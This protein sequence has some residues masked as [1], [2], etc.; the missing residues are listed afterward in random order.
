M[1]ELDLSVIGLENSPPQVGGVEPE[2]GGLDLSV[3]GL[4]NI[5]PTAAIPSEQS[6]FSKG[7][8]RGFNNV[9]A[10]TGDAIAVFGELL[11]SD[12]LVGY[13][14]SVS[15]KNRL[16]MASVG[17]PEVA[18]IEDVTNANDIAPWVANQLGQAI[19]S[20]FPGAT[21]AIAT[22]LGM[23]LVGFSPVGFVGKYS[24]PA[25]SAYLTTAFLGT[26]EASR[27]QKEL[28]GNEDY[29]DA[30]QALKTGLLAGVF[31]IATIIPI[32]RPLEPA[33]KR[34]GK[35]E[36]VDQIQKIFD[37]DKTT[38]S[39]AFDGI[40]KTGG[41]IAT[42]VT[43]EGLTE[44]AQENVFIKGAEQSTGLKV[45]EA[46]AKSR[47]IN[48]GIAGGFGGG[49][50]VGASNI[51]GPLLNRTGDSGLRSFP[52]NS[53][54]A[55]KY[56]N[57]ATFKKEAT[58]K[59]Q[60]NINTEAD[61]LRVR[62][63]EINMYV[64]RPARDTV[65]EVYRLGGRPYSSNYYGKGPAIVKFFK[66]I[67]D[68]ESGEQILVTDALSVPTSR[69]YKIKKGLGEFKDKVL[70]L[71]VGK[72]ISA[73]DDLA[74]RSDT[75]KKIR[76]SLAYFD[77]G[78]ISKRE[79]QTATID[80]RIFSEMG[81]HSE[82]FQKGIDTVSKTVRAP[83]TSVITPATNKELQLALNEPIINEQT[84]PDAKIRRAAQLIRE[85]L[86]GLLDYARN[87][88]FILD[89]NDGQGGTFKGKNVGFNPGYIKGYFPTNYL[90]K[91]MRDNPNFGKEFTDMLQR[92]GFT[93]KE[94]TEVKQ[95]IIDN[96]GFPITLRDESI[97]LDPT[98]KA[99]PIEKTR[100]LKNIPAAEMAPFINTNVIDTFH[101][102]RDAV[103]RRVEY[104][105]TFGKNNEVLEQALKL[106]QAEAAEAKVP[107]TGGEKN[108]IKN[109]AAALQKQ[110]KPIESGVMRKLNA[111][112]I[113]YG[114]V[115]TL[116]F[117]TISSL[118]EPFLIL[119]RGGAGVKTII[120][121]F[122]L[123][124]RGAIRSL[125]PRFPRDEVDT[126]I[127]NIG[128]GLDAAVVE[129]QNDAFGG[130]QESN[131]FTEK[132]FRLN[133]LS[134]FTKFNRTLAYIAAQNLIYN[135]AVFLA[136][137]MNRRNINDV[138][139]L[140]DT[141][142]FKIKKDQLR[143]LGIE[144]GEAVNFVNSDVFKS[145]NKEAIQN[146]EFFQDKVRIGGIRYV[147]EV[148]M[149][150]RATQSPM[151]M[152]DPHLAFLGQ[153]K[154]FQI[155]F[156]NTVLKRWYNEI[157]KTGFYNGIANG[158]R[159]AAVGAVM[160]IAA[161]LGNE[162]REFLQFGPK[163]NPRLK[164]EDLMEQFL[165]AVERT[166]FFG[167]VQLLMDSARAEKY[168]SGPVEALMG[169]IVHRLVSYLEGIRDLLSDGEKEKL[170][171]ELVKSIPILGTSPQI[172]E[173]LYEAL[174]VPT[175]FG[176]TKGLNVGVL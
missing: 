10:I 123:P 39:K 104:A 26:G 105:K 119:S 51:I 63:A 140:P 17:L 101:R 35:K 100:E 154:G 117:A 125:F 16:E 120:K 131:R 20:L 167:P 61:F 150:P 81:R 95:S 5:S 97:G 163:G 110:Y 52:D 64:D 91:K 175:D 137:N 141:G 102:Y 151:W 46:E 115:L 118:S 1:A 126:A 87:A 127:A 152:S 41:A 138:N 103:V 170:I 29:S 82:K 122:T 139:E 132:F 60:E 37:V 121:G 144:P 96:Q 70:D 44:A 172:R 98:K 36:S 69:Y 111:A 128:L 162:L 107:L 157:R 93:E 11:N 40:I 72:S 164:D 33:L 76:Q 75:A 34:I 113:T 45:P 53:G 88:K 47:I 31:D 18:R 57:Y 62:D 129:R 153:L 143:E 13:G 158:G 80:E 78:V 38:A 165:R 21:S 135:N 145:G 92:N 130:G 160:T 2:A 4:D 148:V 83:F 65:R 74:A 106:I 166:G 58:P 149:H 7:F 90:Y 161:A 27:A 28:A 54:T 30:A 134:Q 168:G 114:Y 79:A 146:T 24:L 3:I 56:P 73:I 25:I 156:S 108:R 59:E 77:D 169:P 6:E 112:L 136:K 68:K 109:L 42:G 19:T 85:E 155:T 14:K 89:I 86:D 176:K 133:F 174:D 84:V 55:I 147:N 116:P 12:T 9:Q 48:A 173:Q 171:R 32:L 159:L 124:I 8:E 49:I 43:I 94:A 142:R 71:T 15:L 22:R 99:G 50:Y 66:P 23:G 67:K